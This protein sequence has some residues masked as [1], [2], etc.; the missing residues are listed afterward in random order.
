MKVDYV[1]FSSDVERVFFLELKTDV[2]SRR[3]V[4]D[5]YLERARVVG[6]RKIL[7]GVVQLA[8]ATSGNRVYSSKYFALLRFLAGL[9]FLHVPPD[10]ETFVYATNR[11]GLTRALERIAVTP[12]DPP[13]TVLY[14]Q[15]TRAE[16]QQ[17]VI[18]FEFVAGHVEKHDDPVS[19]VFA[20]YL[21]RW[22]T[23]AGCAPDAAQE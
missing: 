1:L 8:Q 20:K 2:G 15:P 23:P 4:Q 12:L 13:I 19:Q 16:D 5:A 14:L 10:L 17:D 11:I 21:R 9:G 6:F 18:D 7:E 3:E 22:N